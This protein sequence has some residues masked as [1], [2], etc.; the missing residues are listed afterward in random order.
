LSRLFANP[1][2][3]VTSN[4]TTTEPKEGQ[5]AGAEAAAGKKDD[6]VVRSYKCDE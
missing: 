5:E 6:E 1:D 3:P 4:V 2:T